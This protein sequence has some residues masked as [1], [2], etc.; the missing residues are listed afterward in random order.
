MT[1]PQTCH[2]CHPPS[3]MLQKRPAGT[4]DSRAS[5]SLEGSLQSI[6]PKPWTFNTIP[7]ALLYSNCPRPNAIGS[8]IRKQPRILHANLSKTLPRP[9]A[10][11][12]EEVAILS[13]CGLRA[14]KVNYYDFF[15]SLSPPFLCE[16]NHLRRTLENKHKQ[17][18]RSLSFV[19]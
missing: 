1:K 5:R 12:V 18:A 19:S 14:V 3:Y 7:N 6:A 2:D 11:K 8:A 4:S 15:S 16:V 17:A 10:E 13:T 9:Q